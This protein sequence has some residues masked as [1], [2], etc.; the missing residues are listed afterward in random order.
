MAIDTKAQILHK[1]KQQIV[2]YKPVDF[3][4]VNF[5]IVRDLNSELIPTYVVAC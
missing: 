1:L 2:A 4:R 5:G 3:S